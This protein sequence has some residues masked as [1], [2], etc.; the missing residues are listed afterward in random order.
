MGTL[1]LKSPLCFNEAMQL[2]RQIIEEY[3]VDGPRYTSY[4][5]ANV[6][7]TDFD[8]ASY[9]EALAKVKGTSNALSLYIH[10]PFCEKRCLYCA[11]NVTIRKA[12]PKVADEYIAYLGKELD[13][14]AST[15]G[16]RVPLKQVHLGGGTP[17]FLNDSHLDELWRL[18]N[19]YLT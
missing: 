15:F 9:T 4:P 8:A 16:E 11:C 2:N 7:T 10:I 14:I 19:Q 1:V 12:N 13:L 17:T 18:L 5:T 6:W 3:N